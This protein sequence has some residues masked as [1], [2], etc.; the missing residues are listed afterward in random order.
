MYGAWHIAGAPQM[1]AECENEWKEGGGAGLD[2][3]PEAW[4]SQKTGPGEVGIR[5]L[6]QAGQISG[7]DGNPEVAE[8][9]Q[10]A[11]QSLLTFDLTLWGSSPVFWLLVSLGGLRATL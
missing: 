9:S 8:A 2:G 7:G 10:C 4:A 3:V 6:K 11:A 5:L 1:F